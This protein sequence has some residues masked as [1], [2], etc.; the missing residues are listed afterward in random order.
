[1]DKCVLFGFS[2]N[3][4][5]DAWYGARKFALSPLFT[6]RSITRAEYEEKGGEY[7]KEHWASNRYFPTPMSSKWIHL[8]INSC[9]FVVFLIYSSV[10]ISTNPI[11]ITTTPQK[12][13]KDVIYSFWNVAIYQIRNAKM[14]SMS[15][16]CL[17]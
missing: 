16:Y 17:F 15:V 14:K 13:Y 6:T 5:L 3:P 10:K 7:L 9:T 11:C 1:M 8:S 12:I 2:E 4:I